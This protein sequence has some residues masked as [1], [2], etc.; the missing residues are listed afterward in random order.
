[1]K[2]KGLGRS[3]HGLFQERVHFQHSPWE[4]KGMYENF[5]S[6]GGVP[7]KITTG[8]RRNTNQEQ[9]YLETKITNQITPCCTVLLEKLRVTQ[10][11][12]KFFAIYWTRKFIT[13]YTRT[14]HWYLLWTRLIHSIHFHSI[15]VRFIPISFL[16][17]A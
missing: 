7:V 5:I 17:Y 12:K 9:T 13:E 1:V 2:W 3:R 6:I 11:V 8:Y 14:H 16:I 15:S 10:L 4:T